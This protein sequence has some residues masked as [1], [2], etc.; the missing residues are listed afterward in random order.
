LF[1][2]NFFVS[3]TLFA[4]DKNILTFQNFEQIFFC[5]IIAASKNILSFRNFHKINFAK[6]FCHF[7]IFTPKHFHEINFAKKI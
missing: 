1:Q 6:T 2:L 4:A 3:S 5:H 7:E